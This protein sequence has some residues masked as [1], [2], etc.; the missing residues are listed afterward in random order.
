MAA[1]RQPATRHHRSAVRRGNALL[2][3]S[4]LTLG[5]AL[6]SLAALIALLG[7]DPGATNRVLRFIA[8]TSSA[9][10]A[11][12]AHGTVADVFSNDELAAL[13]LV[14]AL[15]AAASLASSYRRAFLRANLGVEAGA[16]VRSRPAAI[17]GR[18]GISLLFA[19][20]AVT[21]VVTG[22]TARTVVGA[23]GGGDHALTLW[24]LGK[25]PLVAAAYVAL[26]L[27]L[28]RDVMGSR[29]ARVRSSAG[30]RMIAV[31]LWALALAG[32]VYY[33]ANFGSIDETYGSIGTT[34]V[35]F[36]WL[37]LFSVLYYAI[38]SLKLERTGAA[39]PGLALS[40]AAW[41]VL[42]ATFAVAA[43][44]LDPFETVGGAVALG[45]VAL[46]W[47]WLANVVTMAGIRLDRELIRRPEPVPQLAVPA[48]A[49]ELERLVR[50]ALEDDAAH[51]GVWSARAGGLEAIPG[52]PTEIEC[53]L[54]DWGFAYGVAWAI[55]KRQYPAEPDREV[56]ERALAAARTVFGEHRGD[57]QLSRRL[58]DRELA[59][60]TSGGS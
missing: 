5:S 13:C 53:D 7:S 46:A 30:G 4:A 32:F 44:L 41:L 26:F 11:A 57:R 21:L 6:V 28:Y 16:P 31:A 48:P 24:N 40:L 1:D 27:L 3:R 45:F 60:D 22:R 33:I 29:P 36:M 14:L 54:N 56:A 43:A 15:A 12:R 42:S 37:I 10:A 18:V 59:G 35:T 8:A 49:A 2:L 34:I 25:W 58:A 23:L 47:L 38:P 50:I 19:A 20:I 51:R 9:G 17:M 52:E 39:V 55:A